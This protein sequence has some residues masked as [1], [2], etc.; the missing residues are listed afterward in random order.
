M[1][2]FKEELKKKKVRN[3]LTS[4]PVLNDS[5]LAKVSKAIQSEQK[6]RNKGKNYEEIH[7]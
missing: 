4:I 3:F 5:E 7:G 1:V 6:A 2:D